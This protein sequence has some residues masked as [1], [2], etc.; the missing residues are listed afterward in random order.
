M[1][2]L[3]FGSFI[4]LKLNYRVLKPL[5][6]TDNFGMVWECYFWDALVILGFCNPCDVALGYYIIVI[7]LSVGG[8]V[9]ENVF[10]LYFVCF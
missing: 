10:V 2:A 5:F 7:V 4:L 9:A 3:T 6:S 1:K 8:I